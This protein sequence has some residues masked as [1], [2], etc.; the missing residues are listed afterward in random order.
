NCFFNN[1]SFLF[2]PG[3]KDNLPSFKNGSY[4]HSY[5]LGW[6][7]FFSSKI[8][9]SIP[10][11]K[12]VQGNQPCSGIGSRTR[13]IKSYMTCPTYSKNLKVQTSIIFNSLLIFQTICSNFLF[14]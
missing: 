9:G 4:A 8:P 3:H 2:A 5:S 10:S 7:I 12:I 13:F 6:N 11:G 14:S 1:G